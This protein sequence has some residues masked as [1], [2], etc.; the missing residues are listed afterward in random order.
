[1]EK[2]FLFFPFLHDQGFRGAFAQN[3]AKQFDNVTSLF[4]FIHQV[5]IQRI[6]KTE[7]QSNLD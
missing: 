7:T 4:S 2:R 5:K 3:Y 1:M 6:S